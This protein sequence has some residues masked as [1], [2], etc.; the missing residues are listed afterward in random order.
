MPQ[1]RPTNLNSS[2]A[3]LLLA[4]RLMPFREGDVIEILSDEDEIWWQGRLNKT[5]G[6][7]PASYVERM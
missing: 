3:I 4:L 5:V 1:R 2:T 7:F 6:L